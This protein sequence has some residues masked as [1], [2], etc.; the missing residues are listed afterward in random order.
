[1]YIRISTQRHTYTHKHIYIHE[2]TVI[3]TRKCK[4]DIIIQ[5]YSTKKYFD[6]S[7]R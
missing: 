6:E 5:L 3:L 2:H 7:G 1:M 4:I